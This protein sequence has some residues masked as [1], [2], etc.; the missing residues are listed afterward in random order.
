MD[1]VEIL[2]IEFIVIVCLLIYLLFSFFTSK[3]LAK[4]NKKDNYYILHCF[5]HF[6]C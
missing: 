3:G 6:H 2:I 5:Y 1:G 4:K